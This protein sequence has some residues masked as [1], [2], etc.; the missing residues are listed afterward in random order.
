MTHYQT[1]FVKGM[2][3]LL[4]EKSKNF[5]EK[6]ADNMQEQ[7]EIENTKSYSI[8]D[9]IEFVKSMGCEVRFDSSINSYSVEEGKSVIQLAFHDNYSENK[10]DVLKVLFHEIWHFISDKI[11]DDNVEKYYKLIQ[12]ASANYFSRAMILP[13]NEFIMVVI[14]NTTSNGMCNIF[15]MAKFFNVSYMDIIARGNDL[16]LWNR[17]GE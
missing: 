6:V 8:D 3:K 2:R 15:S 9:I 13:A 17:K 5:I 7:L 1:I 10:N 14:D 16:N 11:S 4:N 12:D